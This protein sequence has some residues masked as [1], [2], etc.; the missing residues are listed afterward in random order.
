MSTLRHALAAHAGPDAAEADA[1]C[2]VCAP[3]PPSMQVEAS[4]GVRWILPWSHF[5]HGYH[6]AT[7][8][9]ES[10]VL[11]FAQHEVVLRGDNL[12]PLADAAAALRL[13]SIRAWPETYRAAAASAPFIRQILVRDSAETPPSPMSAPMAD[14]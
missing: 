3:Q 8:M 10:L 7:N 2:H 9:E 5:C 4:D 11:M 6:R 12:G 1:P 14:G 13:E